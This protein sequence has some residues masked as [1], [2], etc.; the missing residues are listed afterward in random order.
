MVAEHD[1]VVVKYA[2]LAQQLLFHVIQFDLL[3]AYSL[4]TY[5]HLS[6]KLIILSLQ[7]DGLTFQVCLAVAHVLNSQLHDLERFDDWP[8]FELN[9]IGVR[10]ISICQI[11]QH[12]RHIID[13]GLLRRL[14]RQFHV[15]NTFPVQSSCSL[16]KSNGRRVHMLS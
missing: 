10:Q 16:L 7:L 4:V 2:L 5:F 1:L 9:Q 11:L 13:S 6:G 15:L 14:T 12:I 8:I 3:C